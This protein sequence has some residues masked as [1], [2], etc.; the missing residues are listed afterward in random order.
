MKIC[1][2]K[3]RLW[4]LFFNQAEQIYASYIE[5]DELDWNE[6]QFLSEVIDRLFVSDLETL[7]DLISKIKYKTDDNIEFISLKRLDARGLVDFFNG[8]KVQSFKDS[9]YPPHIT[10]T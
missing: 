6:F 10:E 7:I 1:P 8:M 5:F 4:K 3:I 9:F 2:W